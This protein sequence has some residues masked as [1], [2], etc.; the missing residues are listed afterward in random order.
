MTR[1]G[2]IFCKRVLLFLVKKK[3][4]IG[5]LRAKSATLGVAMRMQRKLQGLPIYPSD[6]SIAVSKKGSKN[7]L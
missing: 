2:L 4:L 3:K 5:D 7:R 1:L 6:K